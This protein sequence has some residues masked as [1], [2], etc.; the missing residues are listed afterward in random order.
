M[1]NSLIQACSFRTV[2]ISKCPDFYPVPGSGADGSPVYVL[3]VRRANIFNDRHS[4]YLWRL[5]WKY[6]DK[7]KQH[8]AERFHLENVIVTA[9]ALIKGFCGGYAFVNERFWFPARSACQTQ[10]AVSR[11]GGTEREGDQK[12]KYRKGQNPARA[13]N[14]VN[15][16]PGDASSHVSLV[17]S[18]SFVLALP[19]FLAVISACISGRVFFYHCQSSFPCRSVSHSTCISMSFRSFLGLSVSLSLLLVLLLAF[20]PFVPHTLHIFLYLFDSFLGLSVSLSLARSPPRVL[21]L[22]F[23]PPASLSISYSAT[24]PL[25][26]RLRRAPQSYNPFLASTSVQQPRVT[27]RPTSINPKAFCRLT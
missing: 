5:R 27:R 22:C 12:G 8:L 14:E 25:S 2:L 24:C 15:G 10:R 20:S 4:N 13:R 17:V 16:V 9:H 26:S 11:V 21:S 7:V 6:L 3:K 23:F 1:N 18:L 19:R